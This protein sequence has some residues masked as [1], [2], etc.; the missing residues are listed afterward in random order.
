MR[1]LLA[2]M[3]LVAMLA[4]P[5]AAQER[6]G[7]WLN[8]GFGWGSLGC[9][10][11]DGRDG[12]VAGDLALGTTVGPHLQLGLGGNAWYKDYGDGVSLALGTIVDARAKYYPSRTGGLY[13]T[14]G[15]GVG[16]VHTRLDGFGLIDGSYNKTG[17]GIV[18]GVGYDV[19]LGQG[20]LALTPFVHAVAV[21]ADGD[22]YNQGQVG[23]AIS[24]QKFR[25]RRERS[26]ETPA[27][28]REP[29]PYV[30]PAFRGAGEQPGAE[31]PGAEQPAAAQPAPAP[32]SAVPPRPSV[33]YT[34]LPPG[35]NYVGDTR[36]K[37]YYPITCAAQ[38]AIPPAFQT[39]FQ[40]EEGAMDD[41]FKRSGDC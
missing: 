36:I 19:R 41:G 4:V 24:I 14:G 31:Q 20:S 30:Q 7:F 11:C 22:R 6:H 40:T 8:L 34:R 32:P 13:L 26:E 9:R 5:S 17:L 12:G 23:L 27:A 28:P 16:R 38:H 2:G 1:G 37:I 18:A 25:A 3:A 33:G 15:V 35:T 39:F 10:G 29:A 21:R